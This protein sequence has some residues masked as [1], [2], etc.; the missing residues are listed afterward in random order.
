MTVTASSG[1]PRVSPQLFDTL[2]LSSVRQAEQQDRFPDNGELNS[3]VTFFRTGQDRIEASRIIAANAEAIV[4][5]AANRIF[6]GG[7][8]LSFLESPLT[9]GETG[10]SSGQGGTPL[11]ADQAAFEQSVRT[12]TGDSGS[13]KRGNFLTRLL[14]GAGGDA[15]IRV[16]LPTGFNAISVAKYGP[17]FMRKSVRDMGWFLRYVG[18]ALVAGDPSILAVNTRGLRDILLENCSLAATNVALQEMRAASA[19]LLRDRPEARQMTIDC[20]NVLLQELAIPTPSTKQRQGSSVQQGLQLPAIYALASEGRQLFEM[21]QGL[22]GAE[23]AEIIRAAYRQV[24]ERDIAKGYSQTPAQ[25]KP[26]QSP[27]AKSRC[28]NSFAPSAAARNIASSST[29]VS[30]TAVLWNWPIATSSDGASAPSRNSESRS[31]SSVTRASMAS[32]MYW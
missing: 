8:P 24:F 12:F 30:S 22:S 6:V 29:T 1:S 14:E 27:K 25:T 2:P 3:L 26:A 15:D 23:K 28:A 17:A 16:V 32:W 9:T 13:T 21:R 19:E 20:F 11:A 18:Y 4:A 7:T 31:P 10:R 5:R